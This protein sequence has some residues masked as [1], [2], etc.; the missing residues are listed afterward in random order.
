MKFRFG[1]M[2]LLSGL[3]IL[4]ANS[5]AY[6]HTDVTTGQAKDL[7]DSNE[8]LVI[9]D[10][11]EKYEF[12]NSK[13]HIPGALN[14]P[15]NSGVLEARY[16]ELPVNDPIL[17]VCQSGGRSNNAANYLD[18]MGF[19]IVYDMLGGMNAWS[20]ETE[21]CKYSGGNG[22]LNFP[23]QIASADDWQELMSTSGDWDKNFIMTS[24][25]DLNDVF[26]TPVGNYDEI[27]FTGIF[28]GND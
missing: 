5:S 15:W 8:S 9:I 22:T 28:D 11:R 14:Y 16:D 18:S 7:I 23:Y 1:F 13:G 17:V 21:P 10:V 25:I 20:L 26:L 27:N 3:I 24:D 19:S 4:A 6:A 12:C 2:S